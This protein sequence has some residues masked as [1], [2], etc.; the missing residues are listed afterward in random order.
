[1]QRN[2]NDIQNDLSFRIRSVQSERYRVTV[3]TNIFIVL[4]ICCAAVLFA[5]AAEAL[6]Q[7]GCTLR[8]AA[9]VF[10]LSCLSGGLFRFVLQPALRQAGVLKRE[11]EETTAKFI[12]DRFP[13]I[14]DRLLNVYQLSSQTKVSLKFSSPELL[15]AAVRNFLEET[16]SIDFLQSVDTAGLKRARRRF[17]ATACVCLFFFAVFPGSLS[18]GLYR[19][20]H[21]RTD[22][23]PPP[24]YSFIIAPGS[25]EIVKG[26]SVA[27]TVHVVPAASSLVQVPKE[28]KL[29]RRPERQETAEETTLKKN[30][31]GTFQTVLEGVRLT[32]EYYVLCGDVESMHNTLTVV[33][34]PLFRSFHIRLDYPAY[35]GLPGRVQDDFAGEIGA[36]AGTRVTFTGSASKPL[37][38]GTVRFGDSSSVPCV[39]HRDK[40]SASFNVRTNTSYWISLTDEGHLANI[41]PVQ[42][43]IQVLPDE[44]PSVLLLEPG[45]NIDI[46]GDQTLSVRMQIKDDYGFSSLRL[47]YR[48][49][50]SRYES[51]QETYT[52]AAV[53]ITAAGT[54]AE[55]PFVW[56]LS[57]LHLAPEDVVEYFAEVFDN[58]AVGG[59]K[60]G[61]T[62]LFTLRLP[63][64]DEVFT[65]IDKEQDRSLDDLQQTL[66]EAKKLKDDIESLNR[67]LKKNKDPDWQTQKKMGE[68]AKK[69]DE[70]QKKIEDV[71]SRFERTTQTM[72]RQNVLS[73]QTLEKYME[74]QQLFK[75]MDSA[76]LQKVLKA[77]SES[78][79]NIDKQQF[80]KAM[81]QMSLHDEQFRQSIERTIELLKRIQIEQK[82]DE[83]NTRVQAMERQQ[84]EIK[85]QTSSSQND[86]Q[87]RKDLAQRQR[88]LA[89]QEQ[90]MEREAAD[91]QKRMEEFFTEMPAK[92][93]QQ[94]LDDM[95]R[96]NIRG[97]IE[98]SVSQMQEGNRTGAQS[99][100][101]RTQQQLKNI[102]MQLNSMQQRMQ[103]QQSRTVINALRRA[104]NDLLELSKEQE[105][106]KNQAQAAPSGSPQLRENAQRQQRVSQD[107]NNVITALVDLSQ[108]SFAVTPDMGKAIGEASAHMTNALRD[109]ELRSGGSASQEQDRAKASLNKAAVQTQNA[110]QAMMQGGGQGGSGS[111]MQQL[112]RMGQQQ[113]AINMETQQLDGQQRA[114]AAARLAQE[115]AAVQK[116]LEQLNAEAKQSSDGQRLLG[117][118]EKISNDMKEVVQNLEQNNVDRETMQKQ[119]RILSRMLDAAKSMHEKDYEQKRK[120]ESGT[121][122]PRKRPPELNRELL[123]EKQRFQEDLLNALQQGYSK[124]Y[125]ELIKKYFELLE[126]SEKPLN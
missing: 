125:Q 28:I 8:S 1:M 45:K 73:P 41:N 119:D 47:G 94:L 21:F 92:E 54:A 97:T 40:I 110:L 83:I 86:D 75:S 43:R 25:R 90:A 60:S 87:L 68:M 124:D 79:Q 22:F 4:T 49:V 52:Y 26:E 96:E 76:E 42:Y 112:Q 50:Q 105:E 111:L 63:S 67:D 35:T 37:E 29:I 3:R 39:V 10:F 115:Q 20:V 103:Q 32:T 19:I 5:A 58:D 53:P 16:Q 70:V 51:A 66:G 78:M 72:D 85:D 6:F 102:R 27:V 30:D 2:V 65:D 69:Y 126:K 81:E 122:I 59:P 118:L 74:L 46:A 56:N 121:P 106:L 95:Q 44:Y 17:V 101:Q 80:Q 100:Q 23:S 18:G 99:S 64:L 24:K 48:L 14:R 15:A 89:K 113:M 11:S 36:P 77:K 12:G 104:T 62:G 84:Q 120:S 114:Q 117:D 7:S 9:A 33:D 88:D 93:M 61:R 91:L 108:K 57:P 98:Q 13:Q 109:L 38:K 71:K 123:N 31:S 34:R 55:I 116:S 82:M 107:L